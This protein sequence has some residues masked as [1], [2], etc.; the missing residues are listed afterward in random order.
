MIRSI[1][2]LSMNAWPAM[3]TLHYDGWVLRCADGYTKR[4][5]SVYPLYPSEINVDKKIKFCESFYRDRSLP[6]VF[7]M[8][9]ASTPAGLDA[10]LATCGYNVD[11]RTNVQLLDLGTGIYEIP[12]DVNLTSEHSEVWHAAFARMNHVNDD[13]R[14]THEHILR[15]ILLDKCYASLSVDGQIIGCGLG[16]TQAGYLGIFDIVVDPEH[17]GQGHGSRLMEA[18]LGWGAQQGAHTAYLQV[19]CNNGPA[20]WMYEKLGFREKYQYWYRIKAC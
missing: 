7:K 18:L 10:R 13:R 15:A 1:E 19:M 16:V 14:T 17:R 3:Q 9:E 8:T 2:E 20:L 5:N 6:P 11:S 4:A 12:G